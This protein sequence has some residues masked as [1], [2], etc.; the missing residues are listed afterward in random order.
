[1]RGVRSTPSTPSRNQLPLATRVF[2]AISGAG[3]A[4]GCWR[5]DRQSGDHFPVPKMKIFEIRCVKDSALA[6]H[7]EEV[8]NGW[9]KARNIKGARCHLFNPFFALLT[10]L[11]VIRNVQTNR[12][13]R[14]NSPRRIKFKYKR[15]GTCLFRSRDSQSLAHHV[16]T[17]RLSNRLDTLGKIAHPY[18]PHARWWLVYS[19]RM[20]HW[21]MR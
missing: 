6:A 11:T 2:C 21:M 13:R 20:S 12:K 8:L 5:E 18:G 19:R 10:A 16:D 7:F 1:M 17:G 9:N 4:S 3:L 14:E 15:Q